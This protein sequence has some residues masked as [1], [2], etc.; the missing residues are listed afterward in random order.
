MIKKIVIA[1]FAVIINLPLYASNFAESHGFSA[2]GIAKGNAVVSTVNDWSS[3]W[4]N[5]AGLGKTKERTTV[6][7]SFVNGKNSSGSLLNKKKKNI[8]Y[9]KERTKNGVN[10]VSISYFNTMPIMDV[11]LNKSGVNPGDN[12]NYGM[13]TIGAAIDLNIFYKMPEKVVS[14]ARIGVGISAVHDGSLTKLNDVNYKQHNYLRYGREAQKALI[15]AGFG[16]GFLEDMFG[17]GVVANVSF[18]GEGKIKL[19]DVAIDPSDQYPDDQVKLDL[20]ASPSFNGGLYFNPG[21]ITKLLD[22]LNVGFLYKMETMLDVS[23]ME[24]DAQ[25]T[26]GG[27]LMPM[28]ISMFDYYHPHSFVGGIS[29]RISQLKPI[30]GT[31][32]T[33]STDLEYQMWSKYKVSATDTIRGESIPKLNDIFIPKIGFNFSTPLSWL[34]VQAG[35]YYQPSML[36]DSSLIGEGNFMDNDVHAASLGT[37]F[38]IPKMGG[39]GGSVEVAVSYQ[40][41]YLVEREVFKTTPTSLNP[42]YT[43][44]GMIHSGSISL[45]MKL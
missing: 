40:F 14:S 45:T 4:Y 5:P 1:V 38:R 19:E 15:L 43:Y 33:V 2:N 9:K 21:K 32:V 22:G 30:I 3:V 26:V 42:S 36:P 34:D 11:K 6:D 8:E 27:V 41:Q 37:L 24:T 35:Y 23:P 28:N 12:L 16:M 44:G 25:L 29:Y 10:E 17:F 20:A 7:L 13:V 39:M 18:G 31:E